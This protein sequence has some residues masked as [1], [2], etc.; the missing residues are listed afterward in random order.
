MSAEIADLVFVGLAHIEHKEIV[1]GIEALLQ[2]FRCHVQHGSSC[3]L[4]LATNAAEMLIVNQLRN[5]WMV[6]A[7]RTVG[8]LAQL[9]F[10]KAHGERVHQKQAS[11]ERLA[12]T[13]D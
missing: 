1:S 10:A 5:C 6:A 9:Q 2:F 13:Q 4:L 7:D 3:P 11:D 12:R 8:V